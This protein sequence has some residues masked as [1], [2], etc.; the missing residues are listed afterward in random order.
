MRQSWE[1]LIN[2]RVTLK[3]QARGLNAQGTVDF[4]VVRQVLNSNA[5]S[6]PTALQQGS[7]R[8][9]ACGAVWPKDK[10]IAAGY[11]VDPRGP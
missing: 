6:Q 3:L 8:A 5:S 7:L 2:R 10:L 4:A 1:R 11:D 9:V